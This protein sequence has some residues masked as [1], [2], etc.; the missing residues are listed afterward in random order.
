MD[1]RINLKIYGRV[2]GVAFRFF[3]ARNARRLELK[4]YVMN[5]PD[6]SVELVA[7]GD[8]KSLKALIFYCEQ[9][10]FFARVDKV[11]VE[12]LESRND[13]SNFNIRFY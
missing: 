1:K 11:D 6:G 8:E 5:I 4:G 12:W 2:Q 3:T 10:P 9:G 13:F 7:D